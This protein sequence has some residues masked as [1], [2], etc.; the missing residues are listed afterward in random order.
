[1]SLPIDFCWIDT[2]K[3]RT[4]SQ[5]QKISQNTTVGQCNIIWT[6]IQFQNAGKTLQFPQRDL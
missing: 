4:K 5:Y 3:Q 2:I 6:T 1:M